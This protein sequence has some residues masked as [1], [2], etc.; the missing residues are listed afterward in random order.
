MTITKK[1]SRERKF[2]NLIFG[3]VGKLSHKKLNSGKE[4]KAGSI[5]ESNITGKIISGK[6]GYSVHD[7]FKI[8]IIDKWIQFFCNFV[9]SIILEL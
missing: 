4:K 2:L 3:A 9:I 1:S 8:F 6:Q 5:R 7:I